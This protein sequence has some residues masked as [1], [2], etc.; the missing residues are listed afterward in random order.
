[1]ETAGQPAQDF[2]PLVIM[3][4]K[5][6]AGQLQ[7]ELPIAL[8][9]LGTESLGLSFSAEA[10]EAFYTANPEETLALETIVIGQDGHHRLHFS[11]VVE[12]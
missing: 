9:Y 2:Q 4:S 7:I 10:R 12:L 3:F 1:M 6:P 11:G 8:L 5:D